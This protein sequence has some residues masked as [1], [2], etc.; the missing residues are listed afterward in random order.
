MVDRTMR[1]SLEDLAWQ[2]LLLAQEYGALT[3]YFAKEGNTGRMAACQRFHDR[4]MSAF[5]A[6]TYD[7]TDLYKKLML[8]LQEVGQQ[9]IAS[10]KAANSQ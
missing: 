7:N 5:E 3:R 4:H 10:W 6:L 1:G 2:H 8:E 9:R